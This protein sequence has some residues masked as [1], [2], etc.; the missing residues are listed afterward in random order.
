M[1]IICRDWSIDDHGTICLFM[2]PEYIFAGRAGG[3]VE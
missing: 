2:I 3:M 1:I